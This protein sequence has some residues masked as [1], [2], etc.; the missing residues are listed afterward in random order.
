MTFHSHTHGHP[1]KRPN[2]PHKHGHAKRYHNL[3]N[4]RMLGG[5]KYAASRMYHDHSHTH[6]R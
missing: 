3:S 4:V 5:G 2:G 6:G 1:R